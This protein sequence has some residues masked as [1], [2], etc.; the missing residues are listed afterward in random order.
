MVTRYLITGVVS[1]VVYDNNPELE[2]HGELTADEQRFV[3]DVFE[4]ERIPARMQFHFGALLA[5]ELDSVLVRLNWSGLAVVKHR[6]EFDFLVFQRVSTGLLDVFI[7]REEESVQLAKQSTR[8]N[9][10]E[11]LG[12]PEEALEAFNSRESLSLRSIKRL[13]NFDCINE[14]QAR[15]LSILPYSPPND[16]DGIEKHIRRGKELYE[17]TE[18][19]ANKNKLFTLI[20]SMDAT[21]EDYKRVKLYP[22]SFLEI[23]TGIILGV[24]LSGAGAPVAGSVIA[25]LLMVDGISGYQRLRD[26]FLFNQ[27]EVWEPLSENAVEGIPKKGL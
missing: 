12:Y 24:A 15:M 20:R 11:A 3:L 1:S 13:V 18:E 4:D 26:E 17:G 9:M 16:R 14:D 7:S 22:M 19:F 25:S 21:S 5:G 27:W 8:Q 10:G 2:P 23:I 6:D